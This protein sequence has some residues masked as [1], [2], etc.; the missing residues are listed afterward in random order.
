MSNELSTTL[1]A[2]EQKRFSQLRK[3]AT[4]SM[5]DWCEAL[6]EIRDARLYREEYPTFED[7][8]RIEIGKTR[9]RI[10]QMLNA[11]LVRME[12]ESVPS[13]ESMLSKTSGRAIEEIAK[14]PP[15]SRAEV[16]TRV[17]AEVEATGEAPTAKKVKRVVAEVVA[18]PEPEPGPE[19]EPCDPP[20][21][22]PES[23]QGQQAAPDLH[24][25][26]SDLAAQVLDVGNQFSQIKRR[27]AQLGKQPGGELCKA[28]LSDSDWLTVETLRAKVLN[29]AYAR[30]CP[31]CSAFGCKRCGGRGW[32]SRGEKMLD[33]RAGK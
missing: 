30:V 28:V 4:D 24:F 15:E 5:R 18:T 6:R 26:A 29:T 12:L 2:E 13:L 17:A 16:A 8:C 22:A 31:H 21:P 20:E 23:R 9:Q 10:N 32:Q 3:V 25:P 27:L 33:E 14:A 11:D 7:F 19:Y 1:T